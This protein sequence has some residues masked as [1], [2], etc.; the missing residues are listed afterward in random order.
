MNLTPEVAH[1]SNFSN[2]TLIFFLFYP[3]FQQEVGLVVYFEGKILSAQG[4]LV[5]YNEL[6]GWLAGGLGGLGGFHFLSPFS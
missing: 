3:V 1:A 2:Q 4:A 5:L 6:A